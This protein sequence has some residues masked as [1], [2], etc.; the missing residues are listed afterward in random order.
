LALE[1]YFK[2]FKKIIPI[3]TVSARYATKLPSGS[4]AAELTGITIMALHS[5]L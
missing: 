3:S 4:Q 1:K 5:N 2:K